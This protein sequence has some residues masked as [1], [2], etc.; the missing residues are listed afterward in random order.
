MA[1]GSLEGIKMRLNIASS[2]T[3]YDTILTAMQTAAN[4]YIDTRLKP[5]TNVPL[6]NPDG[7]IVDIENDLAA[8]YFRAG[9]MEIYAK[10]DEL[11]ATLEQRATNSLNVYIKNTY[12][13]KNAERRTNWPSMQ[14]SE[15]IT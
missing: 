14:E 12:V 7:I 9:N 2:D 13:D 10:E 3:T 11:P 4:N 6:S 5:Y 15:D 1:Y 8:A